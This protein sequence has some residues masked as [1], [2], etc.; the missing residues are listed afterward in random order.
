MKTEMRQSLGEVGCSEHLIS[1]LSQGERQLQKHSPLYSKPGVGSG[2]VGGRASARARARARACWGNDPMEREHARTE[3]TSVIPLPTMVS[4]KV[5]CQI[6][7][8]LKAI[9]SV[10][11]IP[12]FAAGF[13]CTG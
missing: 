13:D 9:I 8:C 3:P 10:Q 6:N 7:S 5:D 12:M 4:C 11:L 1:T 2:G